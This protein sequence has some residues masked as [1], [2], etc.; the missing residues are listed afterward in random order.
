MKEETRIIPW[1]DE[2]IGITDEYPDRSSYIRA[3]LSY[4]V[5]IL[6]LGADDSFLDDNNNNQII[7]DA[8]W[9]L[10]VE[11]NYPKTIGLKLVLV[12]TC[13]CELFLNG[14]KVKFQQQFNEAWF[15]GVRDRYHEKFNPISMMKFN[16]KYCQWYVVNGTTCANNQPS[17]MILSIGA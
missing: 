7:E 13:M 4:S 6:I 3:N 5:N 10:I 12:S 17:D 11:C 1:K 9:W 8:P 14:Y 16:V 15:A 2:L